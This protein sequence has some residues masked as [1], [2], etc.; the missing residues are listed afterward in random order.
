MFLILERILVALCNSSYFAN[1]SI[2]YIDIKTEFFFEFRFVFLEG[3]SNMSNLLDYVKWRGDIPFTALPLNEIDALIFSELCYAPYEEVIVEETLCA[4]MKISNLCE[5]FF[6]TNTKKSLGAILPTDQI[7]TLF[8]EIAQ[9]K[10]F[11]DVIVRGYVNEVDIE[12]EKQFCAMCFDMCDNSTFVAFSGTDDTIVGWKESLNM[13]VFT[14]IPSQRRSVDYLKRVSSCSNENLYLGGHSKGGNLAIYSALKSSKEIQDRIK[15]VYSFDGPGFQTKF[16]NK[17]KDSEIRERIIK[18]LPQGAF[19]GAIFEPAGKLIHVKS[20]AKGLYQHDGFTWELEGAR[21]VESGGP[22]PESKNFHDFLKGWFNRINESEK[23]EFIEAV[24]KLLTVN[25]AETLTDIASDKFK[26]ITGILKTDDA[27]KKVF[28]KVIKN[29]IKER[30]FK[31][32]KQPRKDNIVAQD[33]DRVTVK[34]EKKTKNDKR[35]KA[36]K[37]KKAHFEPFFIKTLC[38]MIKM[39]YYNYEIND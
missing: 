1:M 15:C 4:G 11:K 19:V 3:G 8:K 34:V 33:G 16:I 32:T 27:S 25:S 14:P 10:R 23:A 9:S 21:F 39:C 2:V 20:F 24:Y 22:D 31:F 12:S 18:I 5:K 28:L 7:L 6:N 35:K 13:A 36:K 26:F 17:F 37:Q 38:K 29:F 30:Y